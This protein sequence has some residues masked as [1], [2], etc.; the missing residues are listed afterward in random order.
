[1]DWAM[2]HKEAA[3][4]KIAM[5]DLVLRWIKSDLDKLRKESPDD[6]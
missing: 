1:M 6:L 5:S 2:I 3:N 4:Q